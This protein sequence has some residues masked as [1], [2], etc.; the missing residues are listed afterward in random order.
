MK[1]LKVLIL[2][3]IP[4]FLFAQTDIKQEGFYYYQNQDYFNAVYFFEM[5][6]EKDPEDTKIWYPSRR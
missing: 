1:P 2:I 5:A 4:H 3:L 6:V